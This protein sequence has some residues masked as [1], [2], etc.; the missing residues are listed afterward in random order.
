MAFPNPSTVSIGLKKAAHVGI[1]VSDL[2][3]SVT[4]YQA[5]LDE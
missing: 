5:L 3:R 4:F 2:D 1:A